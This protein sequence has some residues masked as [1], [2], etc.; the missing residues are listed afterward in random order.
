MSNGAFVIFGGLLFV[1]FV[2][3]I[4]PGLTFTE[5]LVSTTVGIVAVGLIAMGVAAFV[6]KSK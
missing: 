4:A 1:V 6:T 3:L 5:Y 2:R